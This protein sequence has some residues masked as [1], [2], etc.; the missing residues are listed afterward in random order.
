MHSLHHI[1]TRSALHAS[2]AAELTAT[3]DA[4]HALVASMSKQTWQQPSHNPKWT[5]GQMLDHIALVMRAFPS[6]VQ[7]IR[8]LGWIPRPPTW[9]FDWL[10]IQVV[11]LHAVRATPHSVCAAYDTGHRRTLHILSALHVDEWGK[12]AYYPNADPFLSGFVTLERLFHY[13]AQH[14]LDHARD[15]RSVLG[16]SS[17]HR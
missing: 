9:L 8:R 15:I 3:R 14:Y 16:Q 7:L 11:R 4:Y 6:D 1:A 10:N 2:I 12:G 5:I 17:A 13:P